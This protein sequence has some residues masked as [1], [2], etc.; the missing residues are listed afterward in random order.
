[1][2]KVINKT[3]PASR[4]RPRELS[5]LDTLRAGGAEVLERIK[6]HEARFDNPHSVTTVQIG[7]PTAADLQSVDA[8]LNS[9]IQN[10]N[11]PHSVTTAQIVHLL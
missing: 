8:N 9:H 6:A 11:N 3:M 2:S 4:R 10:K 5:F 1:M 7:A